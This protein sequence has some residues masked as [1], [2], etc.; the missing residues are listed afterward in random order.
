MGDELV[1]ALPCNLFALA[2]AAQRAMPQAGDLETEG[3]DTRPVAGHA[4]VARVASN[5]GPQ[6]LA[7]LGHRSVHALSQLV[8]DRLRAKGNAVQQRMSRRSMRAY[9]MQTALDG[10]R[11]TARGRPGP[12]ATF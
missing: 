3:L 7:L 4:E 5:H 8:L 2:A 11:Q 6:V 9:D 1:H 12:W 10:I